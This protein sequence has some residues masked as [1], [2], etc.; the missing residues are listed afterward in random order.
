MYFVSGM[1][2]E[3]IYPSIGLT[4]R[5]HNHPFQSSV[6]LFLKASRKKKKL[7]WA[8]AAELTLKH[9][10]KEAKCLPLFCVFLLHLQAQNS[11]PLCSFSN[12][13]RNPCQRE[14][15]C[16]FLHR[17][18]R[19]HVPLLL[20]SCF[21]NNSDNQARHCSPQHG[22]HSNANFFSTRQTYYTHYIAH[23]LSSYTYTMQGARFSGV[24]F[25][26]KSLK[27]NI[28]NH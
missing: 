15:R 25:P 5:T 8:Y 4:T 23:A 10:V 17:Q 26:L 3:T 19:M 24:F 28:G 1:E 6:S 2:Q 9:F 21:F 20:F 7:R 12:P 14:P 16:Q 13:G 22:S 27:G 11:G 18:S